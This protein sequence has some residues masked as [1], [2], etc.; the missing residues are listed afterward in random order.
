MTCIQIVCFSMDRVFQL[1]EY[2][3]TL[4][5]HVTFDGQRLAVHEGDDDDALAASAWAHVTVIARCSTPEIRRFYEQIAARYPHVSFLFEDDVH[6]FAHCLLSAL[7]LPVDLA[8]AAS[9]TNGETNANDDGGDDDHSKDP[10]PPFVFFT[11]DDAFFFDDIDLAK[12]VTFLRRGAANPDADLIPDDTDASL[13]PWHFAFH[14]KLAPSIWRSH[15]TNQPMLP[16][17]PMV[18]VPPDRDV[19]ALALAMLPGECFLTFDPARGCHDWSYPWDL[20]GSVYRRSTVKRV[21]HAIHAKFG[22]DGLSRPNHLEVRGHQIVRE[23]F[24]QA[25]RPLRCA[26]LAR[27]KMHVFAVNQVQDVFEN[28]LYATDHVVDND[29]DDSELL[30]T[31]TGDLSHLLH[32]YE[33]Q[34]TLDE[35]FYRRHRFSSVHIGAMVL[36]SAATAAPARSRGSVD[37][38]ADHTPLVSVVMPVF[39]MEPFVELALRSVLQ[40]TYPQ[41]EIIVIDDASTDATPTI[42]SALAAQDPRIKLVHNETNLG[43]AASLNKGFSL[44]QGT[45]VARMDGDDVAFPERIQRQLQF[46]LEHPHVDILGTSIVVGNSDDGCSAGKDPK[47]ESKTKTKTTRDVWPAFE[48][49]VY[50]TSPLATKWQ[51]L[52]GCFVAHPTVMMHRRVLNTIVASNGALY[53]TS[54]PACED[55]DLW[56]RCAYQHNLTVMNMGDVLLFHRKHALRTSTVRREEQLRHTQHIA[57]TWVHRLLSTPA[58]DS[59]D[60]SS[61]SLSAAP[62]ALEWDAVGTALRP[63]LD[64]DKTY[65]ID[66]LEAAIALLQR[67]ER[68]LCGGK[69]RV[70]PR[71]G[72][73]IPSLQEQQ[74]QRDE[75]LAETRYVQSDAAS[76]HGELAFR[77]MLVDPVRGAALWSAF[78]AEHPQVSRNAFGRLLKSTRKA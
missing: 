77:A 67:L 30:A 49:V 43:V 40:Q 60:S 47:T 15:L 18:A 41:M 3:R 24:L 2:M 14:A 65:S 39:N 66:E 50:P 64:E 17:P 42:L 70:L 33:S 63:L 44:A 10:A 45:F 19:D 75:W 72:S 25:S 57:T 62:P 78:A 59:N 38:T 56:L 61:G 12:A 13:E 11:V 16:L 20:S 29:A 54:A 71:A 52:F 23:Q 27:P 74:L 5:Q 37:W 7:R 8:A 9:S 6:D 48:T 55:Y 28:R 35:A 34:E 58:P 51:L 21:L 4:H 22:R 68:R 53:S 69:K 31:S 26:C 76:R 1:S 46:M 36:T 73:V 32:L